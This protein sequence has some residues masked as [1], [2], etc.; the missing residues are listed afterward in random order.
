MK[1]DFNQGFKLIDGAVAMHEAAPLTL[2]V[3]AGVAL[4]APSQQI[5][6]EL[7]LKRGMLAMQVYAAGEIEISPE[8]AGLIREVMATQWAPIIVAQAHPMLEG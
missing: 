4:N 5:D 7:S 1:V 2:G 3:V 6:G 8:E